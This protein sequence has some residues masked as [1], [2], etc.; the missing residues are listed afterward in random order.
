MKKILSIAALSLLISAN[1]YSQKVLNEGDGVCVIY[2]FSEATV[3]NVPY[4]AFVSN[5]EGSNV[6][7]KW[8]IAV[9]GF[10]NRKSKV[11]SPLDEKN[12]GQKYDVII[13]VRFVDD[14]GQTKAYATLVDH[15]TKEEIGK[16]SSVSA[17]GSKW[18]TFENL[19]MERSK[20]V[21]NSLVSYVKKF[22]NK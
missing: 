22:I 3:K 21:A 18:N 20:M 2:D 12:T 10:F 16:K 6:V 19:W 11:K 7:K 4:E 5:E 13:K 9:T 15:E 17:G 14:D 8:K 1:A